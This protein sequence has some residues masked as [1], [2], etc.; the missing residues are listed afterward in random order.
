MK[1]S[2]RFFDAKNIGD[3]L[4]RIGDNGRIQGFLSERRK[5]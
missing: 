5:S 3:I 1:L 4:Q 2:I